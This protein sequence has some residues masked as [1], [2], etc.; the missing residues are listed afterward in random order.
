MAVAEAEAF[1]ASDWLPPV[2]DVLVAL[3]AGFLF[4]QTFRRWRERQRLRR[5][6]KAKR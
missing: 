3:S 5:L 1:V 4:L 6:P 2:W